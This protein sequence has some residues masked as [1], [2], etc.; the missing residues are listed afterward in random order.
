MEIIGI[1]TLSMI[2]IGVGLSVLGAGILLFL[3]C[4]RLA[5]ESFR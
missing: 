5:K 3:E 2:G 4:I 1:I